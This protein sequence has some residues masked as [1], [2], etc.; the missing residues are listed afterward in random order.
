MSR[1]P[2]TLNQRLLQAAGGDRR[3]ISTTNARKTPS[4]ETRVFRPPTKMSLQ[5]IDNKWLDFRWVALSR[6]DEFMH[7]VVRTD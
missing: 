4:P 7:C 1:V 3:P 2:R 6:L 5:A